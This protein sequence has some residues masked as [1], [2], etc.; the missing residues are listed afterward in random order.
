MNIREYKFPVYSGLESQYEHI[1]YNYLDETL[2]KFGYSIKIKKTDFY[3]VDN[4]LSKTKGVP[5]ACDAYI[6]ANNADYEVERSLVCLFEL[7]STGGLNKGIIQTKEY[8]EILSRKYKS[9]EYCSANKGVYAVVFD[10]VQI[11]AYYYNF[12]NDLLTDVIGEYDTK[13][14]I[15]MDDSV[16]NCFF[17]IFPEIRNVNKREEIEEAKLIKSI[18]NDL[19]A[20]NDLLA[21]K[22]ALMT[23]L[24]AVYGE[25]KQDSFVDALNMLKVTTDVEAH[26]IYNRWNTFKKKIDYGKNRDV[27]DNKLYGQAKKLWVMSQ[28]KKMDLYGFIYE[29]LV[30]NQKK[31]EDGEFYT[32]RHLIRPLISSIF[33]KYL[34]RQWK[35]SAENFV[36]VIKTKKILDPFCGSGGFLY[37][38]LRLFK[39]EYDLKNTQLNKVAKEAVYGFDKNDIMAS[40]LNLYLIGD[41]RTN[42]F[43]VQSS[44]NWQNVWKYEI[45]DDRAILL[46]RRVGEEEYNY[47]QRMRKIIEL[48]KETFMCFLHQ[49]IDVEKIKTEFHINLPHVNTIEEF[50]EYHPDAQAD[51]NNF[52]FWDWLLDEAGFLSDS[53]ILR[54]MYNI[55]LLYATNKDNVPDYIM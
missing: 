9:G 8:C 29:E 22:S 35:L 44:I 5:L 21:N 4:A 42:L 33:T 41:G 23:I 36:D 54:Y 27:V 25:T 52:A 38:I 26:E 28:A 16:K 47:K 46:K 30:E 45:R 48:H 10:G 24:A 40:Y 51:S 20:S 18:K 14:G 15:E 7:E 6:F 50:I 49:M 19:R 34:K 17:D 3:N 1:I 37:E 32:S 55:F 13:K 39:Q 2:G 53:T 43:Q 12:E 31:Q 11:I